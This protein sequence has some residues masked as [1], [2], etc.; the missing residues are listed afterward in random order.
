M[1]CKDLI[2]GM[3]RYHVLRRLYGNILYTSPRKHILIDHR[4][5]HIHMIELYLFC[6]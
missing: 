6:L 5:S 1:K 3:Q 4:W 2:G